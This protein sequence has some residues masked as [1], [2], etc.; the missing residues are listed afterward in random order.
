MVLVK[1]SS[2]RPQLALEL[3][4]MEREI[5][6]PPRSTDCVVMKRLTPSNVNPK[7]RMISP[8]MRGAGSA[9][10]RTLMPANPLMDVLKPGAWPGPICVARMLPVST[11]GGAASW[12]PHHVPFTSAT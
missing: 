4:K 8:F 11:R 10:T 5:A 7:P 2:Q 9:S 1:V 12:M 3:M 6:T